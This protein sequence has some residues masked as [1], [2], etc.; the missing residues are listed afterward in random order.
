MLLIALVLNSQQSKSLKC[1]SAV[2]E[3]TDVDIHLGSAFRWCIGCISALMPYE[4]EG[5]KNPAL[6]SYLK[7]VAFAVS[8][9]VT[10]RDKCCSYRGPNPVSSLGSIP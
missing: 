4:F 6:S 5:K 2:S 1:C 3:V 8:V 7:L 10:F 9:G